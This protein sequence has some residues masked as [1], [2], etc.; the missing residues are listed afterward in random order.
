MSSVFSKK[1][2]NENN[3]LQI[4]YREVQMKVAQ[5]WGR[6]AIKRSI[7]QQELQKRSSTNITNTSNIDCSCHPPRISSDVIVEVHQRFMED[8]TY[9]Y[10]KKKT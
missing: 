9:D 7:S 6:G 8:D 10:S 1:I 2:C 5:F 3:D 4:N